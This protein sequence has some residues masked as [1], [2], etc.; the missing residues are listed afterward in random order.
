MGGYQACFFTLLLGK[1]AI[2][3][4]KKGQTATIKKIN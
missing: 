4:G 2:Y 3:V 1:V